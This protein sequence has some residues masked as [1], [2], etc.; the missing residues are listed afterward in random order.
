VSETAVRQVVERFVAEALGERARD[1]VVRAIEVPGRLHVP[2]GAYD[3]RVL[4][5]PGAPILGRTRLQLE[6]T[7]DGA[8]AKT[9]W[10]TADVGLFGPVVVATRPVGRGEVLAA[11]DLAVDRRD[12]SQMPR[13]VVT[14]PADALAHVTRAPLMA[15][16][17][18]R[19]EQLHAPMAVRRGDVV[20]LVAARGSLRI[21]TPGEV[22][23]DAGVG[24][25]VRVVNRSTRK[26]LYGRVL[27]GGTV[28]VAF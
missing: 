11:D 21:T 20:Q 17:P 3:A 22:R 26:E 5:P 12:L 2:A 6:V 16:A 9:A 27:D 24:E 13:G 19:L 23:D 10:I 7:V 15:N 14:D 8:V 18:V 1:A 28:E 4:L 25:Q